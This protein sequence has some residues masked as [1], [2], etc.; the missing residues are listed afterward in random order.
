MRELLFI[1]GSEKKM[2]R[3]FT[4]MGLAIAGLALLGMHGVT[5][6]ASM[7]AAP[8]QTQVPAQAGPKTY[9]ITR[10]VLDDNPTTGSIRNLNAV[11]LAPCGN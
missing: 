1:L 2:I 11:K 3:D 6:A 8:T 9:T 10:S 5:A 7:F 4:M